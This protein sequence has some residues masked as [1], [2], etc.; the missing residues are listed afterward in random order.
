MTGFSRVVHVDSNAHLVNDARYSQTRKRLDPPTGIRL[1]NRSGKRSTKSDAGASEVE[2]NVCT[3]GDNSSN[4]ESFIP[5]TLRVL[6]ARL[7]S[8]PRCALG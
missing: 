6:R 7:C 1:G 4:I 8:R 3:H 5:C 2:R